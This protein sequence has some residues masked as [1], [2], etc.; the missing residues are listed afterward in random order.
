MKY[1]Y[2]NNGD[3]S[4]TYYFTV[5]DDGVIDLLAQ[6]SLPPGYGPSDCKDGDIHKQDMPQHLIDYI[7]NQFNS[8]DKSSWWGGRE[9]GKD[10][11]DVMSKRN[12][13]KSEW[14]S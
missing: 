13:M 12:E 14:R 2:F 6:F 1:Y 9:I 5:D 10:E 7:T 4:P 3:Y 11:F 8:A